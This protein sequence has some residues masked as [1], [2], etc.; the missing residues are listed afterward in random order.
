MGLFALILGLFALVGL[1]LF[2]VYLI[3]KSTP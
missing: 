2:L 3:A 1:P